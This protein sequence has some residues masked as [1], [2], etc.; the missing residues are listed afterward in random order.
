[1][2]IQS[3]NNVYTKSNVNQALSKDNTKEYL[4]SLEDKYGV[5]ISVGDIKS[6]QQLKNYA[7]S[8]IGNANPYKNVMIS[9]NIVKQMESDP[10]FA[11][12]YEAIIADYSEHAE[13]N[14]QNLIKQNTWVNG[15]S[16]STC[17]IWSA[18]MYID[19][20]GEV[21]LWCHGVITVVTG[22]EDEDFVGNQSQLNND[23]YKNYIEK[24]NESQA[25]Y[26]RSNQTVNS[27]EEFLW[28]KKNEQRTNEKNKT[29]DN[30]MDLMA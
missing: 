20:K 1:M 14:I 17:E 13:Q 21:Q 25:E 23:W 24:R 9:G 29:P 8:C 28:I 11:Q 22:K 26:K 5:N 10:I 3:N 4:N 12:K 7:E 19:E 6:K 27:K 15:N 16:K 18:G 2:R 30:D